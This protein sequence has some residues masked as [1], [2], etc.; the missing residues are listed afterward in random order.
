MGATYHT[1]RVK[2]NFCWLHFTGEK[3]KIQRREGIF[4]GSQRDEVSE[5]RLDPNSLDHI[6]PPANKNLKAISTVIEMTSHKPL[7]ER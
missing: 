2:G 3:T 1:G 6:L 5:P 7:E 4:L